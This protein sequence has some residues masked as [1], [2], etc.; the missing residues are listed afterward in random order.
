VV[1][2]FVVRFF[3]LAFVLAFLFAAIVHPSFGLAGCLNHS[4][5]NRSSLRTYRI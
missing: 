1:F 4:S 3:A 2:R 5:Y